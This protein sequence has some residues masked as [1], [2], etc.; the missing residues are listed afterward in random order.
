MRSWLKQSLPLPLAAA[1]YT[2]IAKEGV[3]QYAPLSYVSFGLTGAACLTLIHAYARNAISAPNL[4][5]IAAGAAVGAG[6][7]AQV[8]AI[9]A[10]PNPGLASA[11]FRSQ[12]A[13][14]V[15][16]SAALLRGELDSVA[17]GAIGM[18]LTGVYLATSG[19]TTTPRNKA[20]EHTRTEDHT[21]GQA[22]AG[23]S[24]ARA[25]ALAAVLLTTKDLLSVVSVRSGIK[26]AGMAAI[27]VTTAAVVA[28]AYKLYKTGTLSPRSVDAKASSPWV[29]VAA[30]VIMA[31]WP[32]L[33]T[34]A[35]SSAPNSG[36]PKAMGLAGVALATLASQALYNEPISARAWGGI[37]L[38]IAGTTGL[39]LQGH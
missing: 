21:H 25:A 16:A 11:V 15:L 5:S 36:Y 31:L 32:N 26:P 39:V 35:M 38:I 28:N 17:I 14:T 8:I 2:L 13:L 19:R 34:R 4:S 18:T 29:L 6:V 24:W 12:S 10:A 1:A 33:V 23:K 3:T 7:V 20:K 22:T 37:A 27:E 9:D 30:S